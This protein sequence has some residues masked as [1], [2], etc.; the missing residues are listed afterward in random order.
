M[1]I[2]TCGV[3]ALAIAASGSA[4]AA[5]KCN[6]VG[7]WSDSYGVNATFTTE[8]AGTAT[9]PNNICANVYKIRVTKLS[10]KVF[11]SIGKSKGCPTVTAALAFASGSCTSASGTVVVGS[12]KLPDTWTKTGAIRVKP[13]VPAL[14]GGLRN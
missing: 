7:T 3:A 6:I 2:I 13:G 1:K 11:D 4:S 10:S 14:L 12:T 9:A 5:K 8:M